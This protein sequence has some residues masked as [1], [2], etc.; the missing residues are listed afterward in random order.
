MRVIA[1]DTETTGT[2]P[3]TDRIVEICLLAPGGACEVFRVNPGVP[4]PAA[5]T[6]VHGIRDEDV[7]GCP[8]F[9]DVAPKIQ[10]IV[11]GAVLLGYNSRNFD[12]LILHA[13][14][15]RAGQPG[16][17]L[18]HLAEI[19]VW[20]VWGELEPRTLSGAAAR[21]LG[22]EHAG[23]HR[24]REDVEMTLRVWARIRDHFGLLESDGI[25]L[26]KPEHELD[27]AGH[28]ALDED[29]H[30]V[31]NFGKHKGVRVSSVDRGYLEWMGRSD[32]PS[33]TK[34][35]IGRLLL[36]G[37]DLPEAAAAR[38]ARVESQRT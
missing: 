5:A 12:T 27:R 2:D 9:S 33:S 25:R 17:H 13:E 14:L 29:G 8:R 36:N 18:D 11:E 31:F 20:R 15:R 1:F 16:L 37:G 38:K 4:I 6:E 28:F 26:T 34:A 3:E 35:L 10:G 24:A 7:A 32:F 23:A 30:V 22:E 19:D 21:W